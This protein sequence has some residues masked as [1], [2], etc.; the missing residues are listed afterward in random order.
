MT[1][2]TIEREPLNF[3]IGRAIE[4]LFSSDAGPLKVCEARAVIRE[5]F[6]PDVDYTLA[7]RCGNFRKR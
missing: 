4:W 1:E 2:K 5:R 3:R 6:G 7:E